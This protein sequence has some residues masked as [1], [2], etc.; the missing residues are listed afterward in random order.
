[1]DNLA[2]ILNCRSSNSNDVYKFVYTWIFP[3]HLSNN[4]MLRMG[5]IEGMHIA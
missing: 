4:S 3:F 1:M 5:K 2:S